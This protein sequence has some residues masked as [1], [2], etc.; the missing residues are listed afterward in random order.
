MRQN[1][2]SYPGER[3][4]RRTDIVEQ[5]GYAGKHYFVV[6]YAGRQLT[7][8]AADET[9]ALF[10]AAKRWGYSFKRPEYHQ[11]ASVAKIGKLPLSATRRSSSSSGSYGYGDLPVSS[12]CSRM[13]NE[14]MSLASES[15]SPAACSG[16]M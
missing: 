7:V 4:A 2:I 13:P 5:P 8:H 16:L 1:S 15:S 12:S 14:K 10:W 11:S 9:A 3:P 6:N